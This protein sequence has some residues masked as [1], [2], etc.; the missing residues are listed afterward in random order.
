M[1]HS[2]PSRGGEGLRKNRIQAII[3]GDICKLLS[4]VSVA[5]SGREGRNRKNIETSPEVEEAL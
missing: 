5:V 1:R 2:R 3:L 4:E